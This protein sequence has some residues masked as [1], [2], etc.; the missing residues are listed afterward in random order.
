MAEG[1]PGALLS[2]R[3]DQILRLVATGAANKAIAHT[4]GIGEKA[5][6]NH[7]SATYAKLRAANRVDALRLRGYMRGDLDLAD[8]EARLE[9]IRAEA[10][11]ILEVLDAREA[12]R[13]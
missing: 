11:T 6:K 10:V 4:L 12:Q 2:P 9:A 3:E 1:R 5:V 8:V 7:L 13:D